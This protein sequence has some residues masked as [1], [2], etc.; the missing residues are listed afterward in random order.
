MK[1]NPKI[2]KFA[3]FGAFVKAVRLYLE[4]QVQGKTDEEKV[5]FLKRATKQL[6]SKE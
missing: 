5:S 6:S 2:S 4:R 3:R 1:V